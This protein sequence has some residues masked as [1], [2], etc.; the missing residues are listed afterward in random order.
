MYSVPFWASAVSYAKVTTMSTYV[1]IT[2][3]AYHL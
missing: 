1:I 3:S 2:I